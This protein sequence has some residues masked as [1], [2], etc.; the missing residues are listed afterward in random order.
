MATLTLIGEAL[1]GSNA[2]MTRCLIDE[3]AIAF[4]DTAPRGCSVTTLLGRGSAATVREHPKLRTAHHPF[5]AGA[6]PVLWQSGMTARGVT[7]DFQHAATP[8]AALRANDEQLPQQRSVT[9][10]HALAWQDPASLPNGVARLIRSYAR[11]AMKH[12]DLVV[13][14]TH[15]TAEV[16]REVYGDRPEFRV[17]PFAPLSAPA[18]GGADAAQSLGLPERYLLTTAR[19]TENGRLDW[20]LDAIERGAAGDVPLVILEGELTGGEAVSTNSGA[21]PVAEGDEAKPVSAPKRNRRGADATGHDRLLAEH[22]QAAARTSIVRVTS[23]AEL[24]AVIAGAQALLHPQRY[25][26]TGMTVLTAL[27]AGVPVLHADD[28]AATELV[29]D[30]G[31]VF[32]TA[33]ELAEQLELL[34]TDDSARQRLALLAG[35]RSR[36]FSWG[37]TAWHIWQSHA[38]L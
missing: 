8:L 10:P 22:P 2:L 27:G 13:T 33:A 16:L 31:Q 7:G 37:G 26:G 20:V 14:P 21:V 12:A 23:H 15:A 28:P 32:A 30:G 6:L 38:D 3:L 19:A 24:T 25:L 29:L 35:D 18:S 9:I 5:R 4:A 36:A 11:R 17:I 34:H 1:P